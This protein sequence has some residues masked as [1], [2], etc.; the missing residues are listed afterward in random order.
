MA[1]RRNSGLTA[2]GT[3]TLPCNG[4]EW[5][6]QVQYG[7]RFS[8]GTG[9]GNGRPAP[10]RAGARR[11][12]SRKRAS[13][14]GCAV[15]A[16]PVT[17]L[18]STTASEKSTSSKTPPADSTSGAQAGYAFRRFPLITPA[19]ASSCGPWQSAAMGLSACAKWRTISSTFAFRRRY[20]GARPPG[21]TRPSYCA[22]RFRRRWR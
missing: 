7:T 5:R 18:P 9:A 13:Q 3:R 16:G 4:Q 1:R 17:S 10:I 22:D 14:T 19:A 8:E 20:S 21:M 12:T 15:Q 2:G 11:S 6:R